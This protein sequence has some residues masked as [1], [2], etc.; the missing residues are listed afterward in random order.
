MKTVNMIA[1]AILLGLSLSVAQAGENSVLSTA[2]AGSAG[3]AGTAGQGGIFAPA[4]VL[5]KGAFVIGAEPVLYFDGP[6]KFGVLGH[7]RYGLMPRFEL[8]GTLG[9]NRGELLVR[10]GVDYQAIYDKKGSIGL[11]VRAGGFMNSE[12][13][14]SGID[15]GVMIGNQFK[16]VNIYGGLEMKFIVDPANVTVANLVGGIHIPFEKKVAFVG[17]VGVNINDKHSSYLS[18]GVLFY[19]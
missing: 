18:G 2:D 17:E 11:L 4:A 19:F 15:A 1:T 5:K 14:G 13:M 7:I 3:V 8:N 12:G 16:L 6:K 9:I 10:G